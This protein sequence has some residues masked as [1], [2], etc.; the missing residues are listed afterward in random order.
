MRADALLHCT[1][2]A[3]AA[4][5]PSTPAAGQTWLVAAAATG[6]WTGHTGSLATFQGGGWTFMPPR[7]GMRIY[8][9]TAGQECFFSGSWRKALPVVEPL[10][11]S[12]VDGEARAAIAD[13]VSAL[14]ALGA[15]PSA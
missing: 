4:S 2:V 14:Q 6:V 9:S 5:A 1:V 10:G 15:L 3:E 11:G 8:D 13:L 12:I 7:E